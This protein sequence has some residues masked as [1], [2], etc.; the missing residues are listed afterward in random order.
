[1]KGNINGKRK[2]AKDISGERFKKTNNDEIQSYLKSSVPKNT[3]KMNNWG[4]NIWRDWAKWRNGSENNDL[5]SIPEMRACTPEELGKFLVYFIIEVTASN[6]NPYSVESLY[7]LACAI[8]REYNDWTLDGVERESVDIFNKS[9]MRFSRFNVVMDSKIDRDRTERGV[10]PTKQASLI[11]DEDEDQL[12]DSGVINLTSGCG[13]ANGAYFY[14][15]LNFGLRAV[16][17]HHN[18]TREQMKIVT[19]N[20]GQIEKIVYAGLLN[21]Q[22][23]GGRRTLKQKPKSCTF[24]AQPTNPRCP[25]KII[26]AYMDMLERDCPEDNAYYKR[27]K[28]DNKPGLTKQ[29]LGQATLRKIMK[30]MFV[31]AKINI[32]G[33]NISGH[34]GKATMITRMLEGGVNDGIIKARSGNS[35][36]SIDA[37]KRP[38]EQTMRAASDATVAKTRKV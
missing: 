37:Y 9:D 5:G 27:P 3:R 2:K 19:N 35:S 4:T 30:K 21:K 14:N 26:K 1:M 23:Q 12:W 33:R 28:I 8:K 20:D 15:N 32:E 6:G 24:Y 18:L 25:G 31:D 13:L 36:N 16:D 7:R 38:S 22:F 29:N 17:E 11:T 34:S 10:L